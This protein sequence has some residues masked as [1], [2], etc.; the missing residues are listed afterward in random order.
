MS[1]I[2]YFPFDNIPSIFM[3]IPSVTMP[4]L[5]YPSI[6]GLSLGFNIGSGIHFTSTIPMSILVLSSAIF[7]FYWNI[8]GGFGIVPSHFG[9]NNVSRG[10]HFPWVS[11][12]FPREKFSKWGGYPFFDMFGPKGFS[13]RDSFGNTF[14]LGSI[15][16]PRGAC[17][18][19][20][21]SILPGVLPFLEGITLI[22]HINLL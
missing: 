19:L 22:E 20:G 4:K 13:P 2:Y 10:F 8:P 17:L 15:P 18:L 1:V 21:E 9:G 14:P 12:S 11:T 3:H 7:L 5:V 6:G 16:T